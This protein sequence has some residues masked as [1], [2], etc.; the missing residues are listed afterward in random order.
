MDNRSANRP[1][2]AE[3]SLDL[4]F[5]PLP[6]NVGGVQIGPEAAYSSGLFAGPLFGTSAS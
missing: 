3:G 5:R 4:M 2:L 6:L 1:S